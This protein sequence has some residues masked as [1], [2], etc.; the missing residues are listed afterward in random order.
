MNLNSSSLQTELPLDDI[1]TLSKA[2]CCWVRGLVCTNE[3]S[4]YAGGSIAVGRATHVGQ[5]LR[6]VPD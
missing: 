1:P 6:V 2:L 4:S 3:L 5:V